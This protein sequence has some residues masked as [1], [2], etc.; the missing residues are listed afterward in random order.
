MGRSRDRPLPLRSPGPIRRG[1][2]CI[3]S[4]FF[5]RIVLGIPPPKAEPGF[6]FSSAQDSGHV[7]VFHR[8]LPPPEAGPDLL[9]SPH[10]RRLGRVRD[11][12]KS[13]SKTS[14]RVSHGPGEGGDYSDKEKE[15]MSEFRIQ[16]QKRR[17]SSNI[18]R[19]S[20]RRPASDSNLFLDEKS[21]LELRRLFQAKEKYEALIGEARSVVVE[22]ERKIQELQEKIL[23]HQV[24]MRKR[25]EEADGK[26]LQK[27][28]QRLE[29]RLNLSVV[30]YDTILAKNAVLRE[31]IESLQKQKSAFDAIF[32]R[33]QKE[34]EDQKWAMEA[35]TEQATQAREQRVEALA[36][37]AATREQCNKDIAQFNVEFR[38]L[39]RVYDNEMNLKAFVSMKLMD[40]SEFEEQ[41]RKE[42]ALK[43][44]TRAKS[45][46]GSFE[47]YEVAYL[48][49]LKLT[50]NGDIDR[51]AKEFAEKEK[52]NFA[53]FSYVT[54]LNDDNE[55]L[56]KRIQSVQVQGNEIDQLKLEQEK[57]QE[58]QHGSLKEIEE[59]LRWATEEG[60]RFEKKA[61][62]SGKRLAQLTAAVDFLFQKMGCDATPIREHLGETGEVTRHNLMH[63]FGI[64]EKK[65]N[66]LLLQEA[67]LR[68][69]EVEPDLEP[70]PE[71]NPFL[72]G[73]AL[74][75]S[76]EP[77]AVAPPSIGPEPDNVDA[78][79]DHKNLRDL[80]QEN[81]EK[82]K[83]ALRE[84]NV[85]II[86]KKKVILSI[87]ISL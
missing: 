86:R 2:I 51:L 18:S 73:S 19:S 38:E 1:L 25:K 71:V 48:R 6:L 83:D 5:F 55:R 40:R 76:V 14:R 9:V 44:K 17:K 52:K 54:E 50:E 31:E 87:S 62:E 10:I 67:F 37:I 26:R 20:K 32:S 12:M 36:S 29:N 74:L 75:T 22:Q 69:K 80:I 8:A 59:K 43:Q 28:T 13:P 70:G 72:G 82:E 21:S 84:K 66:E 4:A 58:V 47:S 61:K 39:Q 56:L 57:H 33:L 65:T 30:C 41:A 77:V 68:Y 3:P 16:N 53:A 27:Q 60:N 7:P 79:L 15:I 23:E 78:P 49:L 45:K 24:L 64:I 42:E 34:L 63:Y 81:L 85:L 35:T 11:N 46:G